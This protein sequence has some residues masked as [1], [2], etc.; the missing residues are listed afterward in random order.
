[1]TLNR[2]KF[3]ERKTRGCKTPE[4][5]NP[6]WRTLGCKTIGLVLRR[7]NVRFLVVRPLVVW[8]LVVFPASHLLKSY[9]C[10]QKT[11]N[12]FRNSSLYFSARAVFL[13]REPLFLADLLLSSTLVNFLHPICWRA[14]TA[15]RRQQT[16]FAT[17]AYT[18]A[19]VQC[20]SRA[21]LSFLQ[22][23]YFLAPV[24]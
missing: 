6:L 17:V 19:L 10:N 16:G 24:N 7:L 18:L 9:N 21:S 5:L 13:S 3:P 14:T 1:M 11:A 12:R 4:R 23:C 2:C 15:T 8:L 20:S 22:T